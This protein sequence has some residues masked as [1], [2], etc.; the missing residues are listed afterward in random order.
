[1]GPNMP[2]VFGLANRHFILVTSKESLAYG[3][4]VEMF[5]D[6]H[7]IKI[8]QQCALPNEASRSIK[9]IARMTAVICVNIAPIVEPLLQDLLDLTDLAGT[10]TALGVLGSCSYIVSSV[11][12]T[13]HPFTLVL[14]YLCS[15]D[16]T[17][18]V[19]ALRTVLSLWTSVTSEYSHHMGINT[20][21]SCFV[22][23]RSPVLQRNSFFED[24]CLEC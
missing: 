14:F 17:S 2:T 3:S 12:G 4:A 22:S 23:Q 19:G 9:N 15:A 13:R 16:I 1:M 8:A 10:G 21:I 24:S 7:R 18:L 20:R 11:L 5:F 6:T